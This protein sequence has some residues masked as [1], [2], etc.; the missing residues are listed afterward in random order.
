MNL[1]SVFLELSLQSKSEHYQSLQPR[2]VLLYIFGT[3][4]SANA[5]NHILIFSA[6]R[7][8]NYLDPSGVEMSFL[9][10]SCNGTLNF[11]VNQEQCNQPLIKM[12]GH[13]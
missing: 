9:A 3:E 2:E 10:S 12:Q 13:D 4:R 6:M 11:N 5:F 1:I 7:C 8:A